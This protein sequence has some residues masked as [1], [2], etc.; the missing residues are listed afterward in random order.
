MQAEAGV[1]VACLRAKDGTG[2]LGLFRP[3]RLPRACSAYHAY[4]IYCACLCTAGRKDGHVA[5]ALAPS[6]ASRQEYKSQKGEQ[7]AMIAKIV[8]CYMASGMMNNP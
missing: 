1:S 5:M 4:M 2:M 6:L 3:I 7:M 8:E